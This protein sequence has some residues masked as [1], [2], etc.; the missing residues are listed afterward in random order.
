MCGR[1]IPVED[2][3]IINLRETL[4]PF[5]HKRFG[6]I[7]YWISFLN[8]R[9]A[10]QNPP[11]FTHIVEQVQLPATSA[12]AGAHNVLSFCQIHDR[13]SYEIFCRKLVLERHYTASVFITPSSGIK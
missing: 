3:L 13:A 1:K 6:M 9:K 5:H 8:Y 12:Q 7:F 2:A 11:D 4:K 10:V